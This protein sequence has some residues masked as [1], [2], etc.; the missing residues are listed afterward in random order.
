MTTYTFS[1]YY[2]GPMGGDIADA[3]PSDDLF[4]VTE[5]YGWH[6]GKR[7]FMREGNRHWIEHEDGR[8]ESVDAEKWKLRLDSEPMPSPYAAV[9]PATITWD[10]PKPWWK[11]W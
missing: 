2:G 3:T 5:I 7:K 9:E 8:I 6:G 4:I 10:E 1:H 11:F